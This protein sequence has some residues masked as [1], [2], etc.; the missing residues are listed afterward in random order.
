MSCDTRQSLLLLVLTI[1]PFS[2]NTL[3]DC[4]SGESQSIETRRETRNNG[5]KQQLVLTSWLHRQALWSGVNH[6]LSLA[7]TSAP[8][9]SNNSMIS[10]QPKN[11]AACSAVLLS[12]SFTHRQINNT[13]SHPVTHLSH[14]AEHH[15]NRLGIPSNI[16]IIIIIYLYKNR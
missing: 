6:R 12:E 4:T 3:Q 16:I 1:N 9:V 2:P 10:V 8:C 7:F 5:V 11:A 14:S 13:L 15:Y